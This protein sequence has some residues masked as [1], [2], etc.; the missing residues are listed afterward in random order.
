MTKN[1]FHPTTIK[2]D[3]ETKE[4]VARLAESIHRSPHWLV[5][6]AVKQYV[7]REEK[8]QAFRQGAIDAWNEYKETGLHVTGDEVIAWVETWGEENENAAPVCHE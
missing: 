7:V 2:F 5:L 3:T 4:R 6:E 1:A 8:R